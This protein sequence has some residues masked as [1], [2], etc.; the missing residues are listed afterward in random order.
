MEEGAGGRWQKRITWP[1]APGPSPLA[2]LVIGVLLVQIHDLFGIPNLFLKEKIKTPEMSLSH[3]PLPPL[4]VIILSVRFMVWMIPLH[5]I[6]CVMWVVCAPDLTWFALCILFENWPKNQTG[7][8]AFSHHCRAGSLDWGCVTVSCMHALS[9][10]ACTVSPWEPVGSVLL[11]SHRLPG[12]LTPA[13]QC[14][15]LYSW[16]PSPSV[17]PNEQKLSCRLGEPCTLHARPLC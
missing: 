7:R 8:P 10:Y 15:N 4:F 17:R 16:F 1:P 6:S 9:D 5:M 12:I 2:P 13:K 11:R 14:A 3:R